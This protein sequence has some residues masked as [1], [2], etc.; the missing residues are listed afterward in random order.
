MS[1]REK[2]VCYCLHLL[3][4]FSLKFDMISAVI[5]DPKSNSFV[6]QFERAVVFSK[7]ASQTELCF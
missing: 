7:Y 4:N 3:S 6:P 2:S 5:S 1:G